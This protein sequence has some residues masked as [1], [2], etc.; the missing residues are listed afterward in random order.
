MLRWRSSVSESL[1]QFCEVTIEITCSPASRFSLKWFTF[2]EPSHTPEYL[3]YELC[4]YWPFPPRW[5][6]YEPLPPLRSPSRNAL[7]FLSMRITRNTMRRFVKR[8]YIRSWRLPTAPK[9]RAGMPQS[10]P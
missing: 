5:K 2:V 8:S 9:S 3:E 1:L 4:P 6:L 10:V 7:L